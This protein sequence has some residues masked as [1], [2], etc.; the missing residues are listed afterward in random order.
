MSSLLFFSFITYAKQSEESYNTEK[1]Y[2]EFSLLK[3]KMYENPVLGFSS[4]SK[5][6]H[7]L[8]HFPKHAK[9]DYYYIQSL[10]YLYSQDYLNAY[11]SASN[12][13]SIISNPKHTISYYNILSSKAYAAS[14]LG[15]DNAEQLLKKSLSVALHIDD[16]NSIIDANLQLGVYYNANSFFVLAHHYIKQ[17]LELAEHHKNQLAIAHANWM[18]SNILLKMGRYDEAIKVALK[19]SELYKQLNDELSVL[20]LM[21]TIGGIYSKLEEYDLASSYFERQIKEA[22]SRGLTNLIAYPK[23][24]LALISVKKENFSKAILLLNE[25]ES[26]IALNAALGV[27]LKA[28]HKV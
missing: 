23:F 2:S 1:F 9:V 7:N 3:D 11:E 16:K 20:N 12:G 27:V 10:G 15:Y 22:E 24:E 14:L 4:L 6:K 21:A 17:T 26:S 18:L 8:L 28:L 13:L 5:Y 19:T 25:I